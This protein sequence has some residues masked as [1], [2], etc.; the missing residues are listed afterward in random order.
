M[1]RVR[2]STYLVFTLV[3]LGAALFLVIPKEAF[4]SPGIN[5]ELSF[6][7]KIVNTSGTNIADGTYN[8]EFIIYSG[9]S[10]AQPGPS[11][12]NTGCAAQWTEDYL[13]GG[14]GQAGVAFSSGTF[15]VNL[16]TNCP[17]T[18]GT[19]ETY[20]NNTAINW[21]S[22]PLYL[23]LQ[24][25]DT[26]TCTLTG[27]STF[28][29]NCGGDGEMGPY[30]LLTS[31]PYAFN[32]SEL[33][34]L[35]SS[36]YVQTAS[37]NTIQPTTNAVGLTV[38]QNSAA[39]P[40]ADVFDVD[41][42][43]STGILE[44]QGPSV[45]TANVV[46][47]AVGAANNVTINPSGTGTLNL[48][49]LAS[50]NFIQIGSTT[51]ASGTQTI[52]IGNDNTTGGTT[53]VTI[54]SGSSA[55]GGTT[56]VQANT[57][58]TLQVG[59]TNQKLTTT[60]AVVNNLATTGSSTTF[61]VDNAAGSDILNVGTNYSTVNGSANLIT[62]GSF[63]TPTTG[64]A[65]D[66]SGTTTITQNTTPADIY[67]GLGSLQ[68]STSATA[69]QGI[70]DTYALT[71]STTYNL[72]F[73][74]QANS[75]TISTLQAG[76]F[77]THNAAETTCTLSPLPSS[78]PVPTTG[79]E[80]YTC[81]MPVGVSGGTY[82]FIRQSDATSRIFY[83]DGVQLQAATSVTP[84]ND[85]NLQLTGIISSPVTISSASDSTSLL[86]VANAAGT[87]LLTVDTLDG[88]VT[89]DNTGGTGTVQIGNTTGA[90]AQTIDI[91]NNG[92]ASSTA[93][94]ALG[95]TIGTSTTT[96]SAGSGDIN[97]ATTGGGDVLYS[98]GAGS[99]MQLSASAVP[100]V[101]QFDITNTG[102]A[103]TSAGISGLDITYVG[104]AA[105]VTDSG[106]TVNLTPGTTSGGVWNGLSV[107]ANATGAVSGVTESGLSLTG[108]SSPGAGNEYG[109]TIGAHW[110]AGLNITAVT[111]L[112]AAPAAS[113]LDLYTIQQASRTMLG[114]TDSNAN[115]FVYQP[116]LYQQA[117]FYCTLN[118]TTTVT[119]L[120]GACAITDTTT[121]AVATTQATGIGVDLASGAVADDEAGVWQ[122]TSN[123]FLGSV[124]DESNGFFYSARFYLPTATYGA[125]ATGADFYFGLTDQATN[126]TMV[127][128][129]NPAG[130]Y[131][132]M[133]YSTS[134]GD[135][136]W[137]CVTK[138]N[139]TQATPASS[140]LAFTVQN[141]YEIYVYGPPEGTEVYMQVN[142]ETTGTTG[143]CDETTD[144]PTDTTAMRPE[145]EL[146]TLTGTAR[147]IQF[148]NM[149]VETDR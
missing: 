71:A 84:Y 13:V 97:L 136:D 16:G 94:V 72:S 48:G 83:I 143:T 78:T 140:G 73:Y 37:P 30:I 14:S 5:Q 141:A 100:T 49:T 126:N 31:T 132:G 95:S 148:D 112:P 25:G 110:D 67:E 53:D 11:P 119:A 23:S 2:V 133:Q 68:A 20:N 82:I 105:A 8:M 45:N 79:F 56:T 86:Q 41:T 123:Y 50:A 129:A 43:N 115:S 32:S 125:G 80:R 47:N 108:P 117:I 46:I 26:S 7:G 34:G 76:W 101:D 120:G 130:N 24:I 75:S 42:A 27:A 51:L 36:S 10:A 17:F 91:G 70:K 58:L 22:Y 138:N 90:V 28:K 12:N 87:S 19:C 66:G 93:T 6:E 59:N 61:S 35:S 131:A 89:L 77:D 39:S 18:T 3:V 124:A 127:S 63:D 149:Y 74:A 33:N 103:I 111:A 64:W 99:N 104:G 137:M 38:L 139:V 40:T 147:T 54:G 145:A 55:A 85:G 92:T 122:A 128:S 62:D 4:A 81:S 109:I 102:Q 1:N 142:D 134:R 65:A 113:T 116:S 15:Q 135:T 107:I 98:E 69:D 9:C 88:N 52:G 29:A 106:E 144:L 118:S 114:S 60:G 44:I 121:T 57:T 21:N 96:I 146:G